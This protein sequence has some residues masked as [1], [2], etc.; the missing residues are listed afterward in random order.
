MAD[1][2]SKKK[3]SL[4]KTKVSKACLEELGMSMD[5]N[6]EQEWLKLDIK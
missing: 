6:A 4:V 2:A 3:E 1:I 5:Y